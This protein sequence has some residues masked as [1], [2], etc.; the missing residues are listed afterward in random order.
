MDDFVPIGWIRIPDGHISFT[1]WEAAEQLAAGDAFIADFMAAQ[2]VITQ[3]GT[4]EVYAGAIGYAD[5]LGRRLDANL[6]AQEMFARRITGS[7]P[8]A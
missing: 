8:I 1:I 6:A 7:R 4:T 3:N 5:V 2:P